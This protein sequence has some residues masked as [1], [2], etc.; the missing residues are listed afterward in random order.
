MLGKKQLE[1]HG[2]E[3]FADKRKHDNNDAEI[4]KLHSVIGK[5]TVENNFLS[6]VLGR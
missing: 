3:I 6:K 2:E 1:E 5:L 4:E